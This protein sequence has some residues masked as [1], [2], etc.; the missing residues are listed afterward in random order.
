[1]TKPLPDGTVVDRTYGDLE[2]ASLQ[3]MDR[4]ILILRDLKDGGETD[5][6][7]E[8]ALVLYKDEAERLRIMGMLIHKRVSEAGIAAEQLAAAN[9]RSLGA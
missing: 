4:L 9:K 6:A 3:N 5:V 2:E 7:F 1:M 8:N